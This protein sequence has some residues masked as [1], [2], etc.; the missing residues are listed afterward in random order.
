MIE[1]T[2]QIIVRNTL[3]DLLAYYKLDSGEVREQLLI[4]QNMSNKE[5]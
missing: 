1:K 5:T 2:T 4:I 3:V